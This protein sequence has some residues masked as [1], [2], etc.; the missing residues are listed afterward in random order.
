MNSEIIR[1]PLQFLV[2]S[3]IAFQL[4]I[5]YSWTPNRGLFLTVALLPGWEK[6]GNWMTRDKYTSFSNKFLFVAIA[7]QTPP[8]SEL[9]MYGDSSYC[10]L[11]QIH[12]DSKELRVAHVLLTWETGSVLLLFLL[13]CCHRYQLICT[14]LNPLYVLGGLDQ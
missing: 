8:C 11:Y 1:F 13:N 3:L 12:T 7:I 14:C 10:W 5:F 6:T 9:L 2:V 4:D